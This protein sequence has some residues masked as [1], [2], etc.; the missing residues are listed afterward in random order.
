MK[1]KV[2]IMA[3]PILQTDVMNEFRFIDKYNLTD[4]QIRI[5]LG[6]A[7]YAHNDKLEAK[8]YDVAELNKIARSIY[9]RTQESSY[10]YRDFWK[11]LEKLGI[12]NVEK[13]FIE[14]DV[15]A[16]MPSGWTDYG[17]A[18]MEYTL[19]VTPKSLDRLKV[20]ILTKHL[21]GMC[22]GNFD[23]DLEFKSESEIT[24]REY[25]NL[26]GFEGLLK[27]FEYFEPD[28][29]IKEFI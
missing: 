17:D 13:Y 25:Y 7:S 19:L 5:L 6:A 28:D 11:D 1:L 20:I 14:D 9:S 26:F 4:K 23:F 24:V 8:G 3:L 27:L 21:P 2:S 12:S 22:C 29:I 18:D 15:T 10:D 16:P